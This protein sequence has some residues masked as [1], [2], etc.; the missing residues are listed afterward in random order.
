MMDEDVV[1]NNWNTGVDPDKRPRISY[2]K[3]T[4]VDNHNKE[5]AKK[6][7]DKKSQIIKSEKPKK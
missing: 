1:V 2:E 6:M 4:Q 3:K 5:I 7:A